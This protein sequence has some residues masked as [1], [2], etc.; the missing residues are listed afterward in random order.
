MPHISYTVKVRS[1][2]LMRFRLNIFGKKYFIGESVNFKIVSHRRACTVR[3]FP[4]SRN[5]NF[6][7]IKVATAM[8]LGYIFP[9]AIVKT[10]MG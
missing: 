10:P 6:D 7:D 4:F 9:F 1:S 2:G 8:Y 3:F 5:V